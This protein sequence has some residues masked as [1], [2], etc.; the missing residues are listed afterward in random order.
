MKKDNPPIQYI[1]GFTEFYKLKFK[2]N[3]N[4]LIPRPETEIL[5]DHTIKL[6]KDELTSNEQRVTTVIDIGTGS[7]CI[8][9]S[10][11]KNLPNVKIWAIDISEKALE[12]AQLNSKFHKTEKK[13]FFLKDDLISSFQQAPDLIVTNLPYIPHWRINNLDPMVIDFEPRIA[14]EG[15]RDGFDVYRKLF[16]QMNEKKFYPKHLIAEIDDT[17]HDFV[18]QE[19]KRTFPNAEAKLIKDLHKVDRFLLLT[20]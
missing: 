20:F 6:L 19:M 4:V 2:V 10:I 3:S 5:V 13:I 1:K 8:A 18:L 17:H 11:A 7:G 15:G 14:L 16:D 9:I 12:V